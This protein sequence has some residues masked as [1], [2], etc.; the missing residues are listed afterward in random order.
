MLVRY[1]ACRSGIFQDI[2]THHIDMQIAAQVL[3]SSSHKASF[4]RAGGQPVLTDVVATPQCIK[5]A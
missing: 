1:L 4:Q 5:G 2:R 3:H